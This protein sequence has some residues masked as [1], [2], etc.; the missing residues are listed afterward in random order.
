MFYS[1]PFLDAGC[2]GLVLSSPGRGADAI[3]DYGPQMRP[4]E[5]TTLSSAIDWA[6]GEGG[7]KLSDGLVVYGCSLGGRHYLIATKSAPAYSLMSP[8]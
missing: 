4:D 6:L 7:F 8:C 3:L 2:H 1:R 5:E